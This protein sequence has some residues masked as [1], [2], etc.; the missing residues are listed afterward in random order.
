MKKANLLWYFRVS[1][2]NHE[3]DHVK[4][5]TVVQKH[6]KFAINKCIN[7]EVVVKQCV[8]HILKLNNQINKIIEIVDN[9]KY[10][11]LERII[12]LELHVIKNL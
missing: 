9:Y 3:V 5:I 4:S 12:V 10:N 11:K 7:G 1:I 2:G 8:L 6:I